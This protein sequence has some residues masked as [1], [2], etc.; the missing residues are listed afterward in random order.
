MTNQQL[1]EALMV[2]ASV[3]ELRLPAAGVEALVHPAKDILA[4]VE[5]HA[6]LSEPPLDHLPF[7]GVFLFVAPLPVV[8]SGG[9]EVS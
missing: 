8:I 6:E 3:R 1:G 5:Q 2:E 4:D 7:E 9:L